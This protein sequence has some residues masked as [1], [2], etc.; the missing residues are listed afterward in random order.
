MQLSYDESGLLVQLTCCPYKRACTFYR[1]SISVLD[2]AHIIT[3]VAFA[4]KLL[5]VGYP[6][7]FI[8]YTFMLMSS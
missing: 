3:F 7:Y 6:I 4:N 8:A 1:F 5:S 2:N